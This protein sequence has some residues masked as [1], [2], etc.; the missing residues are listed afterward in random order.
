MVLLTPG[1]Q[2]PVRKRHR[3]RVLDEQRI[4]NLESRTRTRRDP[5]LSPRGVTLH[6]RESGETGARVDK[7]IG[8]AGRAVEGEGGSLDGE[9]SGRLERDAASPEF[10]DG[11]EGRLGQGEIAGKGERGAETGPAP[12]TSPP[13]RTSTDSTLT[14]PSSTSSEPVVSNKRSE[15]A[16]RSIKRLGPVPDPLKVARALSP[17]VKGKKGARSDE[18][19]A[20]SME[21]LLDVLPKTRAAIQSK[22]PGKKRELRIGPASSPGPRQPAPRAS[23]LFGQAHS[24]DE[25]DQISHNYLGAADLAGMSSKAKTRYVE[26]A[27]GGYL[28][29]LVFDSDE[30]SEYVPSDDE[31]EGKK[32]KKKKRKRAKD[33]AGH[34]NVKRLKKGQAAKGDF[35]RRAEQTAF[36]LLLTRQARPAPKA[37]QRRG[38][39]LAR[40]NTVS[41]LGEQVSRATGLRVKRS[42]RANQGKKPAKRVQTLDARRQPLEFGFEEEAGDIAPSAVQC[43]YSFRVPSMKVDTVA[44]SSDLR[45]RATLVS[46]TLQSRSKNRS[47]QS[48]RHRF[49]PARLPPPVPV[50][51]LQLATSEP[52]Q[53]TQPLDLQQRSKQLEKVDP[54]AIT[55]R[56]AKAAAAPQA[57]KSNFRF[58]RGPKAHKALTVDA[59]KWYADLAEAQAHD[60]NLSPLAARTSSNELRTVGKKAS[61]IVDGHAVPGVK[62]AVSAKKSKTLRRLP[63]M[64]EFT[65]AASLDHDDVHADS[66]ERRQE[67]ASQA[68]GDPAHNSSHESRNKKLS[69]ARRVTDPHGDKLVRR[70]PTVLVPPTPLFASQLLRSSFTSLPLPTAGGERLFVPTSSAFDAAAGLAGEMSS[71]QA[72]TSRGRPVEDPADPFILSDS[73]PLSRVPSIEIDSPLPTRTMSKVP[74]RRKVGRR[75]LSSS[76]S[77]A[78]HLSREPTSQL[79]TEDLV[80][81]PPSDAFYIAGTETLEAATVDLAVTEE[82]QDDVDDFATFSLGLGDDLADLPASLPLTAM[83][84]QA[85]DDRRAQVTQQ[86]NDGILP[87]PPQTTPRRKRRV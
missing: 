38:K 85:V 70:A 46:N 20:T 19:L 7:A 56:P 24:D 30:T 76:P 36:A 74:G 71:S 86:R 45:R 29:P 14:P 5:S 48:L 40:K 28:R 9:R 81:Q 35:I 64:P 44:S 41:G 32:K 10:H 33:D 62:P 53:Q 50:A 75:L 18:D 65:F 23:A 4:A 11:S 57:A 51:S 43:V 59:E 78:P 22:T 3:G 6:R 72:S 61:G 58:D 13:R 67:A 54:A 39:P 80:E 84:Q 82:A 12:R 8:S 2:S 87:S 26:R 60:E 66:D 31:R 68:A 25:D 73:P 55:A 37:A 27:A 49:E 52:Q 17:H 15:P 63:T 77:F 69:H 42:T 21:Q 47:A 1:S 16:Q 34:D 83:A 79:D